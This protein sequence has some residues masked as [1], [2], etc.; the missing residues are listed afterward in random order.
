MSRISLT[1]PD[2]T[3]LLDM[4]GVIREVTVADSIPGDTAKQWVGQAW[5]QT[6]PE[7]G[8]ERVRQMIND[9]LASGI[10][11]FRQI[12]QRF[13]NG[14]EL[15]MEYTTVLLGGRAGL[16]AVGKNLQAVAELQSRLIMAQQTMERDYWKLREVE[17]RYRILFEHSTEP[18]LL[19]R[20]NDLRAIEGNPAA[21]SQLNLSVKPEQ[22]SG[23]DFMSEIAPADRSSFQTMLALVRESGKAPGICI[24]LGAEKKPWLVRATLTAADPAAVLM[25]HFTATEKSYAAPPP[26]N[27]FAAERFIER[28]PDGFAVLDTEGRILHANKTFLE[29]VQMGTLASVVGEKLNRWLSR[30]GADL[31][32]LLSNVRRYSS[33]RLFVTHLQGELGSSSEVEISAAEVKYNGGEFIGVILRD[34]SRRLRPAEDEDYFRSALN[35][36]TEQVGRTSL[37]KLVKNTVAV[38]ERHYVK[39][40]LELADGNRTT[41][42]ELLG[43]SRQ[44][45]YAKLERYDLEGETGRNPEDNK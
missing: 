14:L 11:A 36:A 16:L 6:V 10:S 18:I 35:A 32:V 1:Q 33:V 25:V 15:P 19:F 20:A 31:A 2:V 3:L 40:A 26:E 13:P 27:F 42:A 34:V 12:N 22:F 21:A 5:V 29:L 43:L 23:H 24:H 41:A 7:A 45:L 39:A 44:S 30:P 9:A 38:V 17:T 28:M 37:R 4:D 8:A